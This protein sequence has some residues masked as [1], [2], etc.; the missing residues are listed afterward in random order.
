MPGPNDIFTVSF[1]LLL[2]SQVD[3]N[4]QK[5]GTQACLSIP[6]LEPVFSFYTDFPTGLQRKILAAKTIRG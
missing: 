5:M 6:C 2:F 3:E 1:F 4:K